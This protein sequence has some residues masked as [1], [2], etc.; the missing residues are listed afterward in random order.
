MVDVEIPLLLHGCLLR[1]NPSTSW[2][3]LAQDTFF[4]KLKEHHITFNICNECIPQK[5]K[6]STIGPDFRDCKISAP[7][8][9]FLFFFSHLSRLQATIRTYLP[10]ER[11]NRCPS[12]GFL[13]C[14]TCCMPVPMAFCAARPA[15]CLCRWFFVL[16][17]LLHASVGGFLRHPLITSS[18]LA[19]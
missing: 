16:P 9:R 11:T 1:P 14:Q 6:P 10:L 4:A 8:P 17:G 13:R 7:A 15:A 3:S 18:F 19:H 12:G 2:Q 5:N